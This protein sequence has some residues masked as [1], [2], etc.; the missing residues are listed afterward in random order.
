MKK[1]T[2]AK[3]WSMMKFRTGDRPHPRASVTCTRE[4]ESLRRFSVEQNRIPTE[5]RVLL[6][7][8]NYYN[9]FIIPVGY[10][11][12]RVHARQVRYAWR[13]R[14]ML[15]TACTAGR[16]TFRVNLSTFKRVHYCSDLQ[17]Q[18][19]HNFVVR[20]PTLPFILFTRNAIKWTNHVITTFLSLSL[21]L[22][23][24]VCT[25]NTCTKTAIGD[26]L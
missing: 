4:R 16:E 7:G 10:H 5:T 26:H 17:P 11:R 23:V 20:P 13:C 12:W 1:T 3:D 22:C 24:C 14:I 18:C 21:F 15:N 2:S 9:K 6:T 19:R 8:I 25:I